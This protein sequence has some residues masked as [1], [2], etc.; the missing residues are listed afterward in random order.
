MLA[1]VVLRVQVLDYAR[2]ETR[3]VENR[4]IGSSFITKSSVMK[5]SLSQ[6]ED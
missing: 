4:Q 5:G 1:G 6:A 2:K 3:L